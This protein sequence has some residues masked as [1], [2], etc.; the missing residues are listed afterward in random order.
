MSRE[1]VAVFVRLSRMRTGIVFVTLA[2]LVAS[3]GGDSTTKGGPSSDQTPEMM[4]VAL[5]EL[6]TEDHMFGSGP[7]PFT[8]YLIQNRIDPSFGDPTGSP[9][10]TTRL[11]TD[12]EREAIESAITPFGTVRWIEDPSDYVT[13]DLTPTVDGAAILGVGEPMVETNTGLVPVSMWCGGVCGVWLTYRLDLV[14]D[15]W[16]VT[17]IEGPI[18]VS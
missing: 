3:C 9:D 15:A 18:A 8:E 17:V 10:A 6:V 7:P 12:A 11:L 14:N 4:A 5:V 1:L 2:F 13:T 16:T